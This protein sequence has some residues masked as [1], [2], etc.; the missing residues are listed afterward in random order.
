MRPHSPFLSLQYVERNRESCPMQPI[1]LPRPKYN[2]FKFIPMGEEKKQ[3]Q[4]FSFWGRNETF[5][6]FFSTP[7]N[8]IARIINS[9]KIENEHKIYP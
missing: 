3:K 9:D 5:P 1:L 8:A 2:S 6:Y 7:H 4:V